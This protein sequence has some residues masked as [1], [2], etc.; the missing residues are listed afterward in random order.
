MIHKIQKPLISENVKYPLYENMLQAFY[1]IKSEDKNPQSFVI[2]S[3]IAHEFVLECR[4]QYNFGLVPGNAK[5]EFMG[6]PIYRS[7]DV[8]KDEIHIF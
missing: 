5:L 2:H 7:Y 1:T 3:E 8:P 6:L 4:K